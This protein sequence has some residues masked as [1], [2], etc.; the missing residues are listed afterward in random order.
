M[1]FIGKLFGG[2]EAQP[3]PLPAPPPVAPPAY[4]MP[5]QQDAAG[6]QSAGARASGA[7][8]GTIITGP[9]G[10]TK[11]ETTSNKKLTGE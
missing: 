5:T 7:Y 8:S 11:G 9:T 3:M 4:T 1:G 6:N 2:G 10:L